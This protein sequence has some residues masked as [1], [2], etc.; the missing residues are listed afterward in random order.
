MHI[1]I[2]H[3]FQTDSSEMKSYKLREGLSN[4]ILDISVLDM[5][6]L[7]LNCE[8][9]QNGHKPRYLTASSVSPHV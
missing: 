3:N 8:S 2:K 6:T 9:H 7:Q 5:F 4:A 1:G